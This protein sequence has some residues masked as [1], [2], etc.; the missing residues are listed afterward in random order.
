MPLCGN[1][2][3]KRLWTCRKADRMNDSV[4]IGPQITNLL[5]IVE[6][7]RMRGAVPL[8]SHRSSRHVA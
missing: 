2:L 4:Q 3:S 6:R 5:H 1:S 7:R 8:H